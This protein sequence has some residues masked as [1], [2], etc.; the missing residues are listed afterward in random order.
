MVIFTNKKDKPILQYYLIKIGYSIM[1]F[2]YDS[3]T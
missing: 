2:L 3:T 1:F